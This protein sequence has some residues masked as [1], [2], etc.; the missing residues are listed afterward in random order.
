MSEATAKSNHK[1]LLILRHRHLLWLSH[2]DFISFICLV[3]VKTCRW[4]VVILERLNQYGWAAFIALGTSLNLT[5]ILIGDAF[6]LNWECFTD[7]FHLLFWDLLFFMSFIT[8][9]AKQ[10]ISGLLI[11]WENFFFIVERLFLYKHLLFAAT[12]AAK[13]SRATNGRKTAARSSASTY[14]ASANS[15]TITRPAVLVSW[16]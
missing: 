15:R 2:L 9:F 1:L 6:V 5:C 12:S 4:S 14:M 11:F 8:I 10:M 13:R 16:L 7:F 3:N